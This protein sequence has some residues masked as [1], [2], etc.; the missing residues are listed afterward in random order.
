MLTLLLILLPIAL[1]DSLSMLPLAIGPLIV[2]LNDKA[3]FR[4]TA[5]FV[6]GVALVYV[7][8]GVAILFGMNAL[9]D[10]FRPVLTRWWEDPNTAELIV[11]L[12][13]GLI[14]LGLAWK[15]GWDAADTA[16]PERK[17]EASAGSFFLL[18]ATLSLVGLPGAVPYFGAIDQVL[19]QDLDQASN[20]VALLIYN[21]FFVSPLLFL[22]L[23]RAFSRELS[24]PVF[25]FVSANLQRYGA[26]AFALAMGV[27]GLAFVA[28]AISWFIGQPITPIG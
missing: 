20:L 5:A 8:V 12:V 19:R 24:Q 25:D 4:L 16:A 1:L 23:V 28:D 21:L 13:I 14:L 27:L 6:I 2:A 15:Q 3:A 10:S 22:V 7:L 9:M 17:A 11:Q 26:R 18:G